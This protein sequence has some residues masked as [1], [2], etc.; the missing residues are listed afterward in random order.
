MEQGSGVRDQESGKARVVF[1]PALCC[2][3]AAMMACCALPAPAHEKSMPMPDWA[4]NAAKTATPDDAK[5][6][7]AVILLDEYLITVDAQNHAVERERYAVRIL[8]PQGRDYAHCTAYYDTDEKLHYFHAW[9]LGADGKQFQAKDEDFADQGL[10]E[11]EVLQ[12]TARLRTLNPPGADPGAV[13]ACETETELRPY[14]DEETWAF[15]APVPVVSEALELALPPGGHFADSWR[16]YPAIKPE[17]T[18]DSHLR[19]EIHD[20]PALDLENV[21]S[22]P[23]WGALAARMSVM[24]GDMAVHGTAAQWRELGLWQAALEEHR[25]DPTPE[26]AAKAKELTAGVPDFYAK[27]E[28]ITDYIQKNVRYF[29]IETGVGGW[30][31]H[32]AADI[33]RNGYGDC[34]DKTTLLIAMLDAVGIRAY[35]LHVDTRRGVIDPDAP[36]LMG[37][38]MITAI[39]IPAG[40][41][42]PRL[43]AR[44]KMAQDPEGKTSPE[45]N[46]S[47][48]LLIFDPTDEWTPVGL[49]RSELQGA[50]GN[51]SDGE[52]SQ[53]LR[54][55]VLPPAAGGI[56]RVGKFTLGVDGGISGE[57]DESRVGDAAERERAEIKYSDAHEIHDA[58]EQSL[59]GDLPEL[60]FKGYEFSSVGD[61]E[62]PLGLTVKLAAANYAHPAGPL[63]LLRPRIVGSHVHAVPDVMAGRKRSY[64]IVLGAPGTWRDSFEIALPAGYTVDDAPEPVK[65]DVGFASYQSSVTAR[66]GVLHYES[67]YVVRDVQIPAAD[68]A[69]FRR[70]E[71]AILKNEKSS[72]VLKKQTIADSG[73]GP[74]K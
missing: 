9:T 62:K 63:L 35:Y 43:V 6:A 20:M 36:S 67:E 55:P 29:V 41:N 71:L 65:M 21:R 46:E 23:A 18:T 33:Y 70:L 13:V 19:W 2:V 74:G 59:S 27:L 50:Y 3:V 30:Q 49:I 5:N 16:G 57:I 12:S 34:K 40:V 10:A 52:N 8:T 61:L 66:D 56:T 1:H 58:M 25:A 54:M 64:P 60:D 68:A 39:E 69:D 53:V 47:K 7:P 17:E 14:M 4:V 72:V 32:W 28:R 31:A 26:I 37:N 44:V 24:W 38:H 51:I 42:D 48:D 45:D 15:Q 11:S 73:Q 22:A